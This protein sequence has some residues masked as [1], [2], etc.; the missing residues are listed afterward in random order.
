[1]EC[2]TECV[3]MLIMAGSDVNS[4][5]NEGETPLQRAIKL[6]EAGLGDYSEIIAVLKEAGGE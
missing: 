1:M 4:R 6:Q 2:E 5:T 3:K